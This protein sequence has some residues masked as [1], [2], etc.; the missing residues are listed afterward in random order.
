MQVHCGE[1]LVQCM[2]LHAAHLRSCPCSPQAPPAEGGVTRSVLC[3]AL[4]VLIGNLGSGCA[5]CCTGDPNRGWSDEFSFRTAPLV[6]PGALPYRLG[7]VGDLGQTDHSLRCAGAV[8]L[9]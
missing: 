2:L 1:H 6:G 5:P 7:L 8:M 4:L 9:Q 3:L